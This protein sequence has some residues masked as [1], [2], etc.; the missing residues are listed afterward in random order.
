MTH[1]QLAQALNLSRPQ[2]SKDVARG[3]PV[4]LPGA[5]QWRSD[6][7]LFQV[8]KTGPKPTN[9]DYGESEASDGRD[10]ELLQV[11]EIAS[12]LPGLASNEK[13]RKVLTKAQ[14]YVTEEVRILINTR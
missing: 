9:Y 6:N 13:E 1:K 11:L 10:D 5:K 7:K 4:D 3:M 2:I 12:E 14:Q 8:N